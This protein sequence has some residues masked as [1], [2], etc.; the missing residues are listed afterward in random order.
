MQISKND[1]LFHNTVPD[2]SKTNGAAPPLATDGPERFDW[3]ND[4]DVLMPSQPA[5]AI[6]TNAVGQVVIRQES[7]DG[8]DDPYVLIGPQ[9]LD[10]IIE[11]LIRWRDELKA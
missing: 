2:I 6:Y 11:S 5:T 1:D 3:S 9:Y 8:D 10:R 4:P 7:R